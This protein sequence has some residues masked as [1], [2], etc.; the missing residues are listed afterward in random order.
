MS[1]KESKARL[2]ASQMPT[3]FFWWP[4]KD[5]ERF[6]ERVE[7]VG[8]ENGRIEA[9]SGLREDGSPELWLRVIDTRTKKALVDE[10]TDGDGWEDFSHNCPPDCPPDWP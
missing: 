9:A 2:A 3:D 8:L 1:M 6:F 7:Q 10:G 5:L 4:A